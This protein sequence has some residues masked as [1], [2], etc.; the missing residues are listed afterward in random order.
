MKERSFADFLIGAL[1]C[2]SLLAVYTLVN[3]T[4]TDAPRAAE[5]E[6][7]RHDDGRF[8]LP[9]RRRRKRTVEDTCRHCAGSGACVQCGPQPCRVCRGNGIQPRD[10]ALI[11]R[12][13]A[14]W[15]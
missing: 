9:K 8:E 6:R 10:P 2:M 4:Q 1:A 15:G 11:A 13:D 5:P 3:A 12:L 14:L 7:S